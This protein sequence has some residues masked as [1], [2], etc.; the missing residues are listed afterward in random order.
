MLIKPAYA[1][2][3]VS[4]QRFEFREAA[5]SVAGLVILGYAL[6]KLGRVPSVPA[7]V[8][9]IVLLVCAAAILYGIW[10]MVVSLAFVFVKVDNLSFLVSSI[11]DAARWPASVF[12][13]IFALIFTFVLPLAVMTTFPALAIL[14]RLDA[15]RMVG[16]IVAAAAFIVVS[17]LVWL[18]SIRRYTSAGG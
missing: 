8:A 18:G 4:T 6:A 9:T 5:D 1:Q 17:R 12:R 11:F 10:I 14:D 3:L 15:A 7:V 16:A 2:F 13:G